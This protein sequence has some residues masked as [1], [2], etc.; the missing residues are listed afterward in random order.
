MSQSTNQNSCHIIVANIVLLTNKIV[1]EAY[2]FNLSFKP[3]YSDVIPCKW[4]YCNKMPL[5]SMSY[6]QVLLPRA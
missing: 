1:F 2:I 5:I 4:C 3:L 6:I